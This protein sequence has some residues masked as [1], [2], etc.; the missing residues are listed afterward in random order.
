MRT[1]LSTRALSPRREAGSHYGYVIILQTLAT[2]PTCLTCFPHS[3]TITPSQR[4]LPKN[5]FYKKGTTVMATVTAAS[6]EYRRELGEGLI[7][8]WSTSEDTENI[9]QLCGLVFRDK[10]DEPLNVR[11]MESVRRQM[12]GDFPLMGPGDYALI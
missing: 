11:A 9:A 12:S 1:R 8:R 4:Q 5:L 10:E 7:E 3:S 2:G 6:P